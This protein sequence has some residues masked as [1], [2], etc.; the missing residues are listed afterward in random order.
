MLTLKVI[1]EE[2]ERVIKGLEKKNFPNAANAIEEVIETDKKRR[3]AQTELDKNLSEAKKMA[4]QIGALM[5]QGQKEEAEQ[6]KA[7][8]A[9]LKETNKELEDK[10]TEAEKEMVRLLCAI[11]NIPYD[12]VPEGKGA[13]ENLVVKSNLCECKEGDTVGNWTVVPEK[14]EDKLPH[15][16]LAKKYNL[17]DFDLGVKISGAGFPVYRGKGA[18]LQRALINF[19]L[20]EARKAGYEEIMPPTVVNADSGYGTGQLPDK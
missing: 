5:K 14:A 4:A 6:I 3:E 18:Q 7:Q 11:P 12:L 19:F 9:A 1:T 15:W 13:E 10:K 8:V 16:E 2:K 20:D 17:I